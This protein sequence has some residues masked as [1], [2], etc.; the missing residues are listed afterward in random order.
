M[1]L[2]YRKT[3]ILGLAVTALLIVTIGGSLLFAASPTSVSREEALRALAVLNAYFE[4]SVQAIPEP[5]ST[6]TPSPLPSLS[7]I[8]MPTP[9]PAVTSGLLDC[10]ER[11]DGFFYGYA[12]IVNGKAMTVVK[13]TSKH[14]EVSFV[15]PR[16]REW[17]YGF[18]IQERGQ[19]IWFEV[20]QDGEW[21]IRRG[22]ILDRHRRYTTIVEGGYLQDDGITFHS[23]PG[24]MNQLTFF[25]QGPPDPVTYVSSPPFFF[26][27]GSAVGR[28]LGFGYRKYDSRIYS[29]W[30][31]QYRQDY[32]GLCSVASWRE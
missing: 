11:R 30:S 20:R 7:P 24:E 4:Q 28:S 31:D 1:R 2:R 13:E 18:L 21:F 22:S 8:P 5:T 27:N 26:V 15:N 9:T 29:I 25:T 16:N 17:T 23:Q 32:R 12:D 3:I 19:V 6:I 14:F 10:P